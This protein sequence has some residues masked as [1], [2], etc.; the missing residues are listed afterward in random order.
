MFFYLKVDIWEA[1]RGQRPITPNNYMLENEDAQLQRS[2]QI[3]LLYN[4][5]YLLLE[6]MSQSNLLLHCISRKKEAP[7]RHSLGIMNFH[8]SSKPSKSP[9]KKLFK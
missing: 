9:F 7:R 1:L 6:N 2:V 4:Y 3:I 5:F 8:T